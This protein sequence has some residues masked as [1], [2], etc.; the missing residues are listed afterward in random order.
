MYIVIEQLVAS[1]HN[2]N[3]SYPG[4]DEGDK[5][6]EKDDTLDD[7]Y[8]LQS[9][10]LGGD[11][12]SSS[13]ACRVIVNCVNSTNDIESL[14]GMLPVVEDWHAKLCFLGVIYRN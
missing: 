9:M 8:I 10:L 14:K 5:D 11:Q 2:Y 7:N 13:M 12:L 6:S 4:L 3:W 1:G